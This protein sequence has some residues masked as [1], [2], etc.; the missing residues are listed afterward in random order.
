MASTSRG[1]VFVV[2]AAGS[3]T[4][5]M[6]LIL[7]S[8]DSIAMAQETG[9]ARVLQANEWVPFWEFGG[10]WYGR[11]GLTQQ[12]LEAELGAFY[13]GLFARFAAAQGAS[14]WGEK[15]PFH[16]WHLGLLARVF[17]DAVFIGMVRHPG[18]VA[19]STRRRM[20]HD[21]RASLR[22]W[23]RDNIEL[24]AAGSALGPR[25]VLCRYEDL[26]TSPEPVLR[27]LF[28]W[29]GEPWSEQ[30]LAFHEVHSRRGTEA[31]VEGATRSDRPLD[32]SRV[33]AWTTT[34]DEERWGRLRHGQVARVSRFLGYRPR[35]PLPKRGWDA[36][37]AGWLVDGDGL[38]LRMRARWGIDWRSRP[39][40]SLV[41]RPLK[42]AD[43]ARLRARAAGT[44]SR[45]QV[46]DRLAERAGDAGR[47]A[48]R[49][50]PPDAR[51]RVRSLLELARR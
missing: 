11:I 22:F 33:S 25:L 49:R 21:W 20:G 31:E 37:S 30:V 9:L 26:L 35:Q 34:M 1:P 50:L 18:A 47:T 10:E 42:E 7:D 4:T 17:P 40:P 23:V 19:H 16:L 46:V 14:R 48:L 15:T 43:L 8:H 45:P 44:R 3:G 28:G 41:N 12:E 38:A 36:A 6:R 32:A 27:E 39:T 51:A 24:V 13:G 29:L 2:G 5:L